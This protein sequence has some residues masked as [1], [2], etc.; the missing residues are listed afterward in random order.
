MMIPR[1]TSVAMREPAV[2]YALGGLVVAVVLLGFALFGAIRVE[3]VEASVPPAAIADS[4]LRFRIPGEGADVAA[5]VA[6]DL[7]TDDRQAPP[8]R[9]LMPGQ[10]DVDVQPT[11]RPVV[12]GTAL[13]GEGGNFAICQVAGAPSRIV[14]VGDK[15]GE[16]SVLGIERSKVT[17]RGADGERFTIDASKPVP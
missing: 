6:S 9:Y 5:A 2:R 14:R 8:R 17:F 1:L 7:F 12:L 16:Y 10:S 3:Q 15:I 4:A 13:G 11:P